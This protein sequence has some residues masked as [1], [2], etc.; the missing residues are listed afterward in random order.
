MIVEGD[1]VNPAGLESTVRVEISPI[2]VL[3]KM[4][5]TAIR[6]Y[7]NRYHH[8]AQQNSP[9]Y[10]KDLAFDYFHGDFD[11][12]RF[13]CELGPEAVMKARIKAGLVDPR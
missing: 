11:L 10:Y 9:E 4:E 3:T 5:E 8:G 1:L 2:D 12:V 6:S 7:M 13:F